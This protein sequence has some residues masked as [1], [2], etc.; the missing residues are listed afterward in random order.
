MEISGRG[1]VNG[2]CS[3]RSGGVQAAMVAGVELR[4]GELASV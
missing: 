3:T 1:V 4:E 2:V